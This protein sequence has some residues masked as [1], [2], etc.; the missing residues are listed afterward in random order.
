VAS[1]CRVSPGRVRHRRNAKPLKPEV[2][3]ECGVRRTRF[4]STAS[5]LT[6]MREGAR[7]RAERDMRLNAMASLNIALVSCSGQFCRALPVNAADPRHQSYSFTGPGR[8]C[9]A[10]SSEA[11]TR[12]RCDRDRFTPGTI[13][14]L[15]TRWR[16]ELSAIDVQNHSLLFRD[17][18]RAKRV[19]LTA[20][21]RQNAALN[22]RRLLKGARERAV[23][24][25]LEG[26]ELR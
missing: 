10:P 16:G 17:A 11:S 24:V 19:E 1:T 2:R 4:R 21:R 15:L 3:K 14:E 22:C 7:R 23:A 9:G 5:G 20:A 12:W 6:R 18:A 8:Y 26:G 13:S 25:E